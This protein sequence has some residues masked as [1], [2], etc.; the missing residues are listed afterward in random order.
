MAVFHSFAEPLALGLLNIHA[1]ISID[2]FWFGLS[3]AGV[4]VFGALV[5]G[6]WKFRPPRLEEAFRRLDRSLP[7]RPLQ[8]L[9]DYQRLGA[10]DPISKEMWDAHQL[11]LEGEVRKARPVPP[12]LSLSTRDPYG[13]RFSALFFLPWV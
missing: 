2:V 11:R 8:G 9:S 5:W 10:S 1:T 7:A 13:L 3:G 12:D 6:A 4:L